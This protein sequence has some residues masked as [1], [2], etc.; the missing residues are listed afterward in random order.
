ML[1]KIKN[2]VIGFVVLGSISAAGLYFLNPTGRERGDFVQVTLKVNW[3][4]VKRADAVLITIMAN[5]QAQHHSELNE[6][7]WL[8]EVSAP[9]GTLVMV[10]ATQPVEGLLLQCTATAHGK[11]VG[12]N[13]ATPSMGGASSCS[14]AVVA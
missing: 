9:K 1:Q 7:P 8:E 10:A 4:P 5:G 2:T 11:T 14:A 12:P 13:P 3:V 6:S